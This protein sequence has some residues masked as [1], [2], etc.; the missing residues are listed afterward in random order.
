MKRSAL[1]I[2]LFLL[3]LGPLCRANTP[4]DGDIVVH[5]FDT[6]CDGQ[7]YAHNGNSYSKPG[8]YTVVLTASDGRDSVVVLHL[9]VLDNV[10][11]E[12]SDTICRGLTYNFNGQSL[13][14]AGDYVARL[15][16]AFGCD[17]VV[18]LH[19][20]VAD[21][22]TADIYDTIC[23]GSQ[24]LFHG[25]SCSQAGLYQTHL[26][27]SAG[28]DSL[29]TLHLTVIPSTAG[30]LNATLCN[31]SFFYN[32]T[33]YLE[34][35]VYTVVLA[36][37]RGCDSVVTLNLSLLHTDVYDTICEG[38]SYLF[39][40][41]HYNIAGVYSARLISA[42]GCDSSVTLHLAVR[43]NVLVHVYDSI[44]V[45]QSYSFNGTPITETGVYSDTLLGHYGCDSAVVL[46]LSVLTNFSS[47]FSQTICQGQSF[48]F[49]DT[50]RTVSGDYQARY[51]SRTGCDS[52]VT[53]HLTVADISRTD[54]YDTICDGATLLFNGQS[55]A[56]AGDYQARLTNRVGCDSIVVLH[57]A[58]RG[59]NSS[60]VLN[61]T[62]C[63][64]WSYNL[65]GQEITAAGDYQARMTTAEGCDSVVTLHLT[66]LEGKDT[67]VY[68]RICGPYAIA[69][70]VITQP[71][72]YRVVLTAANGC[73][74]VVSLHLNEPHSDIS[75]TI[76]EGAHYSF[77]GRNLTSEGTYQAVIS[78]GA[79][80]DSTVTL[81]LHVSPHKTNNVYDTICDGDMYVF[82][83]S[84]YNHD[85]VYDVRLITND[86]CDSVVRLHLHVVENAANVIYEDICA[87][88]AYQIGD[89]A[90]STSGE[91]PVVLQTGRG[92]DSTVIV[93]LTVHDSSSY[94]FSDTICSNRSY[95][96]NGRN[97]T[98]AG[99]YTAQLV[100]RFG[101]DSLVTLHLVVLQTSS[102][103]LS[104]SIC[105]GP[106]VFHG[107]TYTNPGTYTVR[108][109]NAVGCDSVI[110]L[111]LA[112]LRSNRYDTICNGHSFTLNGE[113]YTTSGT[114]SVQYKSVSGCDSIVTLHLTVR[115][116]VV[117]TQQASICEGHSYNFRGRTL[118]AA[119][120]YSDTL[121][122]RFGC[123][124]VV[125]LR[126]TVI[127]AKLADLND[128]ICEGN[129]YNFNGRTLATAGEYPDTL[130][131]ASGCDSIVTLHLVVLQ[132]SS[133]DL[134]DTICDGRQYAFMGNN[135]TVAGDYPL[136]LTNRAGCDSLVTLHLAV[137]DRSFSDT[138][139]TICHSESYEF[140]GNVYTAP[141]TYRAA[142]V[143]SVGCDS[144][145]SLHLTVRDSI[146]SDT[147]V[148]ICQGDSVAFN[149]RVYNST[150]RYSATLRSVTGCDSTAWLYLRVAEQ[151][152]TEVYDTICRDQFYHLA[153]QNLNQPGDYVA[154]LSSVDG[155]DSTVN[156]HLHVLDF[157]GVT[158]DAYDT[159]CRGDYY[160]S[161]GNYYGL[162]GIYTVNLTSHLGCDSI[163]T[164][165][166]H[167][168]ENSTADV[169][170]TVCQGE[171]YLFND[172][173]CTQTGDYPVH[174][175]NAVGC[176]S[177]VTLHLT[178]N[179]TSV[180]DVY[181]TICDGGDYHFN[182]SIYTFQGDYPAHLLNRFGCDSTVTLHLTVLDNSSTELFDTICRG[183][184][185]L[186]NGQ[187][188][189]VDGDYEAHLLNA[190]GCDSA[191]L[192]H[193]FV[194]ES[195]I[196]DIYD[197]VC[198]GQTYLFDGR[199]LARSGD[200]QAP[201]TTL[202][203]CDSIVTLHLT[204]RDP[205]LFTYTTTNE[206]VVP[207]SGSITLSG[208]GAGWSYSVNGVPD[209]PLEG[210]A[211]GNYTVTVA[212]EFGC[213]TTVVIYVGKGC[214]DVGFT[215]LP[216]ICA[217]DHEADLPYT[218]TNGSAYSYNLRFSQEAHAQGFIDM[219]T[220]A[221]EF[222][223]EIRLTL[224]AAND[225]YPRPDVYRLTVEFNDV[226][227]GP[228]PV[229]VDLKVLY[230]KAVLEQKWNDVIA[231]LND[232]YNNPHGAGYLFDAFQWYKNGLPIPGETG[233]YLYL[234]PGVT[235]DYQA[236]DEYSVLLRRQ[237]ETYSIMSCPI[238]PLPR[239]EQPYMSLCSNCA[240]LQHPGRSLELTNI[241][242]PGV[243]V[244]YSMAGQQLGAYRIDSS[245]YSIPVP[246]VEGVYVLHITSG[247]RHEA[248]K[249]LVR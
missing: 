28:C 135:Y 128:T 238:V 115:D 88:E 131:A 10:E 70:T 214:I 190:V 93:R 102:S 211:S 198:A 14:Q 117:T 40:G 59:S 204:V 3:F 148:V 132:N 245:N 178:V 105:D 74:S 22:A 162:P 16:S 111:R 4:A 100:N 127:A 139:A 90:I 49:N 76:C 86:G 160:Y 184:S 242:A 237:G 89:T 183:D 232:R 92:C 243:A 143:N 116:P 220:V 230:S 170:D 196:L 171:S 134:Y 55:L 122:S 155:C 58:L 97:L 137:L 187:T 21:D 126:L 188:L 140:N 18:T 153:G 150:G 215:D 6:I 203:G 239:Q 109:P 173:L 216:D 43:N 12:Y 229:T 27:S 39:N 244:W 66:V 110:L 221:F 33:T 37:A 145:A 181:D 77:H 133:A 46:H 193:L 166:L 51:V 83:G 180:A 186:F 53:L 25:Q 144:T 227:C 113:A 57:L 60:T 94:E 95:R 24:Y 36:N 176:D 72:V 120:V 63:Q 231:V 164:L 192:L 56:A 202:L 96:F 218:L 199:T 156:L 67:V 44:C 146:Y 31:G 129:T 34:P 226:I 50:L 75:D 169:Y 80:C 65:N 124:S 175:M 69:D 213:D 152:V 15:H 99:T 42:G 9:T 26:T 106:Y 241:A 240:M 168:L 197:T 5:V 19:L 7:L 179:P 82:F 154:H 30:V 167:V 228:V 125:T 112:A 103:T 104:D 223:D 141:G 38:R 163:V 206:A 17:S 121:V 81:H 136:L 32:D 236:L 23:E 177:L 147:H 247:E 142:L 71:G 79:G 98:Q 48:L 64:G 212:D 61:E 138:Y 123:D 189:V 234:G 119:G 235:F 222:T 13:M 161:N 108:I 185:L 114:Y 52:V 191:V 47:E 249:V 210:L 130:T 1:L 41:N 246:V 73:D 54:L 20:Y 224:P 225:F 159:V 118:T 84:A 87:G 29:V 85:G 8:D 151:Y 149:G 205:V 91:Y 2:A 217:D 248:F 165:Y 68:D 194:A 207:L 45:G 157:Y 219:D 174:L 11:V 35:G 78:T 209:G 201:F 195:Y 107:H 233:S 172:T 101:C 158:A 62:I 200:Y 182:D 208:L